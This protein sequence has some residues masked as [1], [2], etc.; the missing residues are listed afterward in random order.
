MYSSPDPVPLNFFDFFSDED[1]GYSQRFWS[2]SNTFADGAPK[3][4]MDQ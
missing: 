3:M 1:Q 2:R 4:F